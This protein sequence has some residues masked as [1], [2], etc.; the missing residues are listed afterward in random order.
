MS[1]GSKLGMEGLIN[2]LRNWAR[3][4]LALQAELLEALD[5]QSLAIRG[6]GSDRLEEATA[7]VEERS[8]AARKNEARRTQLFE[9]LAQKWGVAPGTLTFA[10]IAMRAGDHGEGLAALRGEL[11]EVVQAVQSKARLVQAELRMHQRIAVEVLGTLLGQDD[12]G[13]V[14]SRGA[15]LNAEA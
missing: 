1:A 12:D 5:E 11:R 13:S 8:A 2:H 3:E 7:I 4:E 15:L 9:R 14:T 10:S 6:R